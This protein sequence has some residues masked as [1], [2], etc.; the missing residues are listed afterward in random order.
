MASHHDTASAYRKIKDENLDLL[1]RKGKQ[2]SNDNLLQT[3]PRGVATRL[4]DKVVRLRN[5][6]EGD[7]EVEFESI[8][9]TFR[10]VE[11]YGTIGVALLRGTLVPTTRMV[12]LAGPIDG[13][14]PANAGRWRI[15]FSREMK[16]SGITCFDPYGA[17]YGASP[18]A[19]D[20]VQAV[21]RAAIDASQAV[22]AYL[23]GPGRGFGTIREIEY[24]V[25]RGK[26][27]I[28][29]AADLS[30]MSTWDCE[31]VP[32][33]ADASRRITGRPGFSTEFDMGGPNPNWIHP[34]SLEGEERMAAFRKAE[35]ERIAEAN[36]RVEEK[37]YG[38]NIEECTDGIDGT[39]GDVLAASAR[40]A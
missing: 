1:V 19:A 2:Y 11:N 30:V 25:S 6:L 37:V 22:V 12:Y 13:I 21:N 17:F 24:A 34:H 28:V 27:V 10:D 33:L 15:K 36:K 18:N 20:L 26:R 14:E 16:L 4:L 3:G 38:D 8:E 7:K 40:G 23:A 39:D 31:L 9:D 29:V 32:T 35:D 5:L